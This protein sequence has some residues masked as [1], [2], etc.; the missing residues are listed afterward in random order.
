M[1]CYEIIGSN[2]K[3]LR[4]IKS[5]KQADMAAILD[6]KQSYYSQL[7]NAVKTISIEQLV[8]IADEFSIELDWFLGRN[9]KIDE[10]I[11]KDC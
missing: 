5:L 10:R 1:N 6:I 7:E 11:K 8:K 2:L 4:E 3:K 9:P